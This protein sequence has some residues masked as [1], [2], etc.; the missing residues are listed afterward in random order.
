MAHAL[1]EVLQVV[2]YY[3]EAGQEVEF[4]EVLLPIVNRT[5]SILSYIQSALM[6][7]ASS[8]FLSRGQTMVHVMRHQDLNRFN[9]PGTSAR[10]YH[11][12]DPRPPKREPPRRQ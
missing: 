8:S 10:N 4:F 7:S 3:L 1:N 12:S 2:A 5:H 6:T 11:P 9:L